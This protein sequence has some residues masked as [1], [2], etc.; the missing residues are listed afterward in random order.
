MNIDELL[1]EVPTQLGEDNLKEQLNVLVS[2]GK[3]KE[4][5][6]KE[7]THEQVKNLSEEDVKKFHKRYE[8]ALASKT[9]DAVA[10]SAIK[11]ATKLLGLALPIDDV[12]QLQKDL[13]EDYIIAQELKITCGWLSLK[14]GK[15]MA[16]ASGALHIAQHIDLQEL[17]TSWSDFKKSRLSQPQVTASPP[18]EL[19]Q[20]E[21]T[22]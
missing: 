15:L 5:I 12:R 13:S 1:D 7:L 20:V 16:L 21:S 17:T 11:L 18:Q 22:T 8:A 4:M 10:D 9:T 14:C 6:G 19:D 3:C 2:S